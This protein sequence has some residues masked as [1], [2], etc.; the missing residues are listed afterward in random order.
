MRFNR[1]YE[2]AARDLG[3]TGWQTLRHVVLP[4]IAPSLVG[5]ALF[6]F[7][8]SSNAVVVFEARAAAG[9]R[10]KSRQR[11]DGSTLPAQRREQPV[12]AGQRD[13]FKVEKRHARLRPDCL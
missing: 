11:P 3:A 2:E 1:S 7:T 9:R 6:G 4:I 10:L 8:L 12:R 5:V 13:K